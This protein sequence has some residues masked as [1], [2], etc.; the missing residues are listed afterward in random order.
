MADITGQVTQIRQA[1]YGEEVRESIASSIEAMNEQCEESTAGY[2]QAI[3]D[4][5]SALAS[6]N[7]AIENA[8]SAAASVSGAAER[9]EAAAQNA[10]TKASIADTAA[11]NAN[12][13]A[14]LADTAAGAANIAAT[15]ASQ[16]AQAAQTQAGAA[17]SAAGQAQ[18]Q[19]QA[20]QNAA[21]AANNA[22]G[23]ANAAADRANEA[24][25]AIEGTEVGDLAVRVQTLEGEMDTAQSGISSLRTR[26]YME[27]AD[28]SNFSDIGRYIVSVDGHLVTLTL[29]FY[30]IPEISAEELMFVTVPPEEE[31]V[32]GAIVSATGDLSGI[33]L[34][35][36]HM[37]PNGGVYLISPMA[38]DLSLPY[39]ITI[40]YPVG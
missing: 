1:I 22:A 34:L 14:G 31:F 35:S 28:A 15:S 26:P 40:Q 7:D 39:S 37:Y 12:T 3:T 11:Q 10:N 9:A 33:G 19:A 30:D 2:Q 23:S 6:A 17:E 27:M 29:I 16:A 18:A 38:I 5:E 13:K 20:A 36:I 25:G 8:N 32:T 24:A 4:A 21:S